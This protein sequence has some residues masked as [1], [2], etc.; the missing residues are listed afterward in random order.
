MDVRI[1]DGGKTIAAQRYSWENGKII[2]DIGKKSD[3]T[4]IVRDPDFEAVFKTK[5][6]STDKYI[7]MHENIIALNWTSNLSEVGEY[8]NYLLNNYHDD[9]D[10]IEVTKEMVIKVQTRLN[11]LGYEC[12]TADGILGSKSQKAIENFQKDNGINSTRTITQDL[13]DKLGI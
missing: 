4:L 7:D 9:P 8:G 1:S 3:N 13:L 10:Q 5:S 6:I 12:G 11:E 2:L